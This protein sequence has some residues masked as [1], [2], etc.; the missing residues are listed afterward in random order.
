MNNEIVILFHNRLKFLIQNSQKCEK[1][2]RHEFNAYKRWTFVV[3]SV[4]TWARIVLPLD[5]ITCWKSPA[6]RFTLNTNNR[7]INI[8]AK[9]AP[10]KNVCWF[11]S[12]FIVPSSPFSV[13][14]HSKI[15]CSLRVGATLWN[16]NGHFKF[17][18]TYIVAN[19]V[20]CNV[21]ITFLLSKSVELKLVM[22]RQ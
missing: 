2:D 9:F 4:K 1:R 14:M 3:F 20:E 10:C 8:K 19:Q 16:A 15:D 12:D 7:L 22:R 21:D 18:S 5:R 11:R 13:L 17:S 6:L